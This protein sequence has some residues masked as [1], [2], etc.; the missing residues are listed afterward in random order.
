MDEKLTRLEQDLQRVPGIRSARIVG[1]DVATE[2]HIVATHAR[3]P[4]QLVRDVQSLAQAGFGLTIDHRIVSI[5]QLE[6]SEPVPEKP[7][8]APEPPSE[9][10][11]Q[12]S[13]SEVHRTINLETDEAPGDLGPRPHRPVLERVV[14]ATKGTSGWVKV[15]LRWAD[16]EVTE[17]AGAAGGSREARARGATL[18][19]LNALEPVLSRMGASLE[20]DHVLV[21][22]IGQTDAVLVRALF[23]DGTS[24]TPLVGSAVVQDDVATAAVRAL[25]HAINRKLQR[26]AAAS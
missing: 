20:I 9:T 1:A 11:A 17:G 6:E 12:P 14:F 16:G 10:R 3:S 8:A 18:A 26:L 24:S 5:V 2:I 19:T 22:R 4:K 7:A 23:Y 15:A 21:H 25:L 13:E